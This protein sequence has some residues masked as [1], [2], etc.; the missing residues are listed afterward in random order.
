ME[1]EDTG[2][3][4][5]GGEGTQ[6]VLGALYLLTQDAESIGTTLVDACN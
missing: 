4:K 2:E 5:E 6:R 3:A 1:V